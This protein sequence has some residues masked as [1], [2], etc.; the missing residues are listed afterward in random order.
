LAPPG[1]TTEYAK[2]G[3]KKPDIP[4][5]NIWEEEEAPPPKAQQDKEQIDNQQQLAILED[6]FLLGEITETDY[7]ELKA[8]Y[9][10]R[11]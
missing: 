3:E 2:A 11:K 7:R 5:D 10:K 9:S 4:P 8:K 1:K 6:K